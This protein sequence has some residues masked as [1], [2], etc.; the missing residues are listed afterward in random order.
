M[1]NL[2]E[3]ARFFNGRS[4]GCRAW[5]VSDLPTWHWRD[6]WGDEVPQDLTADEIDTLYTLLRRVVDHDG[7]E[8][9][10]RL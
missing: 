5:A 2:L 6:P 10:E 7:E 1:N 9:P 8:A 4:I 3:L